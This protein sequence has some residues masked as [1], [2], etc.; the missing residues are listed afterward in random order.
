M[1][2]DPARVNTVFPGYTGLGLT[3]L[4]LIA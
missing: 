3:E 4:N 2:A 1:G